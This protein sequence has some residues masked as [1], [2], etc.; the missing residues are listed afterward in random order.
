MRIAIVG[1]KGSGKTQLACDLSRCLHLRNDLACIIAD[2]APLMAAIYA[3]LLHGDQTL[4]ESALAHH[5]T[6][7]LTLVA[8]LDIPWRGDGQHDAASLSREAVDAQLRA[9]LARGQI[10]YTVVYGLGPA[11]VEAALNAI[12]PLRHDRV[13]PDSSARSNWQWSCE[14]CSDPQCE[15]RMFTGL[16]KTGK[17]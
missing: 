8:G 1:A 15:H 5:K 3:D 2:M 11:R 17:T 9:T 14:K 16:L 13:Q 10:A 6:Y 4:Y 7:D 12:S